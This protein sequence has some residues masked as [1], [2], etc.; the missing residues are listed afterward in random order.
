M[1]KDITS[2]P[3]HQADRIPTMWEFSTD[4]LIITLMNNHRDYK[5]QWVISCYKLS[6]HAIKLNINNNATLE[7]AQNFALSYVRSELASLLESLP[8]V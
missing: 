5:G 7:Q 8:S 6:N 3:R 4:K 1:W 2:Y